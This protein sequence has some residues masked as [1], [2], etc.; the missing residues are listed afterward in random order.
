VTLDTM[1]E[2]KP[3]VVE[4]ENSHFATQDIDPKA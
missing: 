4:E 1:W 3:K 2:L